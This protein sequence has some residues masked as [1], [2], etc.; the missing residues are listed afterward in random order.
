M[1]K[2]DQPLEAALREFL[3]NHK[4]N[5]KQLAV[6][7]GRSQG[8]MNKYLKGQG[9]ATMDD[10]VRLLAIVVLGVEAPPLP[11]AKRRLLE[12]WDVLSPSERRQLKGW[13]SLLLRNRDARPLKSAA[14]LPQ[15]NHGTSGKS[16]GKPPRE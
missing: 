4:P 12:T 6:R 1:P 11:A 8:W 16:S 7:I 5:Q 2:L 15:K 9:K 13:L 3:R 10:V 14:P